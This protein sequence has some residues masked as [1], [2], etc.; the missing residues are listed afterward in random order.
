[1]WPSSVG[2]KAARYVGFAGVDPHKGIT[3]IREL[4]HAVRELGLRGLNLQCFEHKLHINDK[5][6]FP[7]YA[8]CIELDIPVNI[9][10]S[11]QFFIADADGLWSTPFT[12]RGDGSFS[13]AACVRRT[14]R[15][16]V[17]S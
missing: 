2:S 1:M 13:G 8:K 15:L 4:E 12:R 17:G 14:A 10:T 11:D 9:H 6:M 3:A 5:K 16:A 7:L